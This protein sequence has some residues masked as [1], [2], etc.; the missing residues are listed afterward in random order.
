MVEVSLELFERK[1]GF[2]AELTH[3][4][5]YFLFSLISTAVAVIFILLG[6][7]CETVAGQMKTGITFVAI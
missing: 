2:E 5:A 4:F 7:L 1:T 6:Y 3:N